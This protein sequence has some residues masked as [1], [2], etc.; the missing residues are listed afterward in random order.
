[1]TQRLAWQ[2][3]PL[4]MCPISNWRLKGIS[5]LVESPVKKAMDAGLPVTVNSDDPS[6]FG[7][8]LN[9]NYRAVHQHLGLSEVEIVT[10]AKNS[11]AASFLSDREKQ[12]VQL[13]RRDPEL[14]GN[15]AK[16]SPRL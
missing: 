16:H 2:Q 12:A 10:L 9:D 1:M 3:T 4:T 6:Y 11:L 14:R 15:T 8:C 5:S 7:G 13:R